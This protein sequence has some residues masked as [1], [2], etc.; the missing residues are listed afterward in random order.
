MTWNRAGLA[1]AV[2]L[3]TAVSAAADSLPAVSARVPSRVE[4]AMPLGPTVSES[5]PPSGSSQYRSSSAT[6]RNENGVSESSKRSFS[7]LIIVV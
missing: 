6:S 7:A 1:G 3:F 5:E 4:D 2:V